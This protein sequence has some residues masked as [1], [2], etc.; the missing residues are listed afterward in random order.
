[1]LQGQQPCSSTSNDTD[2]Y[3][4]QHRLFLQ[5]RGAGS[6]ASKCWGRILEGTGIPDI[7]TMVFAI[8]SIHAGVGNLEGA[9]IRNVKRSTACQNVTME[10]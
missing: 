1:M 6:K 7:Q 2:P 3:Q 8:S 9:G 5:S 10:Q 4:N